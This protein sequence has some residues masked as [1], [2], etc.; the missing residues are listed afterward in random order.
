M[1]NRVIIRIKV[2]QVIYA[3]YQRDSKDLRSAEKELVRS[4]EQSYELYLNLLFLIV[5]LTDAEQKRIDVLK[6]KYL[7]TEEERNPNTRLMNNR[8][9]EQLRT[10]H[11][12]ESFINSHGNVWHI[13]DSSFLKNLLNTILESDIYKEY[14]ESPDTYESDRDFWHKVFK[15]II[16]KDE[17]LLDIVNDNSIYV[18][19][20]L[21][22][23]ITFVMKTIK[24]FNEKNGR[25]QELLPMFKDEEDVEFSKELLRA[26]ISQK[27][28]NSE[29]IDKQ[30]KNWDIERIALMDLYIMQIALAELKTFPS[31][32]SQVTLN[33]YID[34]ARYYSTPHS[35]RFVNGILDSIVNEMKSEGKL[36][37]N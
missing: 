21:D 1:I 30:I 10:N 24:K 15:H 25:N 37:K 36:F 22:L 23:I 12:L 34:L 26:A 5:V 32:P 11:K 33:E 8:F 31:I 9:A 6:H 35:V 13:E 14:T 29:I 27:A 20:E 19:D 4:I 16:S 17:D 28:E 7:P 18:S 3:F 2:L